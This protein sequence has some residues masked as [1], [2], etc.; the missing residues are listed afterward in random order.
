MHVG[1]PSLISHTVIHAKRWWDSKTEPRHVLRQ[2]S[3][4]DNNPQR[5]HM[6][7]IIH[8][9]GRNSDLEPFQQQLQKTWLNNHPTWT[10]MFWTDNDN[11]DL[12]TDKFP[13]FLSVYDN[14]PSPV[15]RAQCA[16]YFYMLEYA[17]CYI[18]LAFE[19]LKPMEPLLQNIQA[20]LGYI[21]QDTSNTL[22]ISSA[23]T[24]S[25]PGHPFWMYVI[26]HMLRNYDSS[27]VDTA[28]V[29]RVTGPYVLREAVQ[30]YH[31][32]SLFSDLTILPS[33]QLFGSDWSWRHDA[34]KQDVLDMCHSANPSF[35]A[36]KCKEFFPDAYAVTYWSGDMT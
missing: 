28:D 11:R 9:Y 19:S 25:V 27:Q 13:W 22:S 1:A 6:P 24:A 35:N 29:F 4:P 21:T 12:I 36:T 10:Y 31:T 18:D 7:H 30:E 23:F 33:Q 26:K 8:Q 3:N 20:A 14:L 17:G 16:H 32:R 5:L 34:S 15:Q 2:P